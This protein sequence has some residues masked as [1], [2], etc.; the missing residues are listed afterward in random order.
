MICIHVCI[1]IYIYNA[2][3][4]RPPREAQRR[5]R[6][7]AA[8]GLL[9]SESWIYHVMWLLPIIIIIRWL[10]LNECISNNNHLIGKLPEIISHH[11]IVFSHPW[12]LK[13]FQEG[14]GGENLSGDDP[15][16]A[17]LRAKIPDFRGFDSSIIL[18]L[19]GFIFMS[20][21]ISPECL[22]QRILVGIILG[23]IRR[24]LTRPAL[25]K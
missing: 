2:I 15:A 23:A 7:Q 21:G 13:E 8:Q 12:Q 5:R 20:V 4:P 10:F 6:G 24:P 19:R 16:T 11:M 25:D 14:R 18:N 22:S 3:R 17:N 9:V 1:Y